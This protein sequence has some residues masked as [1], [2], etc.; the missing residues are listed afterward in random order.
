MEAAREA[1]WEVARKAAWE[2]A[3]E[4]ARRAAFVVVGWSGE[5][6]YGGQDGEENGERGGEMH[7]CCCSFY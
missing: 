6:G 4:A 7:A 3:W 2:A 5:D 1:A